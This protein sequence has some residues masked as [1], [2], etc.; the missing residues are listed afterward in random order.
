MVRERKH[1]S[2]RNENVISS[3]VEIESCI[4]IDLRKITLSLG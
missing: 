3:T 4:S 2:S 1:I